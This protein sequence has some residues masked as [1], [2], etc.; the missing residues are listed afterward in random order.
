MRHAER[1][2]SDRRVMMPD[3]NSH[4]QEVIKNIRD[5][6]EVGKPKV[7]VEAKNI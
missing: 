3:E 1:N 2:Y 4:L 7:T 6:L 5:V